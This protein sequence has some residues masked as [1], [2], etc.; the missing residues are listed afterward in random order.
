LATPTFIVIGQAKCGTTT[1]CETLRHH[2]QV[3]V[4]EPKEPHFFGFNSSTR[5]REWYDSLYEGVGSE[6]AVGE[7]STSYT[8]P[9]TYERCARS[10][11]REAP[12][13]RFVYLA[14]DPIARLESDWKM[15]VR[16]G[17][18]TWND[19]NKSLD[20]NPQVVELGKY[21]RNLSSYRD[22]FPAEQ[23]L[24]VLL[25]DLAR[26]PKETMATIYRHL[27]V[28]EVP[29]AAERPEAANTAGSY[30]REG[31]IMKAARRSGIVKAGLTMLPGPVITA[32]KSRLSTPYRYEANW[33][34]GRLRELQ[35]MYREASRPL[36]DHLG[37]P[38]DFWSYEPPSARTGSAPSRA[39]TEPA[40]P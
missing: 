7:G 21:W 34:P 12:H 15:R 18:A 38:R 5:S 16:E 2:P 10:I 23:L 36:L 32:L 13:A 39:R 33:D 37:K 6:R 29:A 1:V 9:D 40:H 20:D 11:L 8:R 25:E 14:R 28:D 19:I 3:F 22:L 17:R 27:G 31:T 24:I 26:R 4:T 30:R 35:S